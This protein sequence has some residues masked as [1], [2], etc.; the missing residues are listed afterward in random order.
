MKAHQHMILALDEHK[1]LPISDRLQ[2]ENT[3]MHIRMIDMEILQLL[4]GKD[5][6]EFL[7]DDE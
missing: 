3:C 2:L 6:L 4:N 1:K 7:F 5:S